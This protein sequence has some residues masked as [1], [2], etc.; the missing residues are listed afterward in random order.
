MRNPTLTPVS[1]LDAIDKV[2]L[3]GFAQA[4]ITLSDAVE[5]AEKYAFGRAVSGGLAEADGGLIFLVVVVAD[6]RLKEV[7]IDPSSQN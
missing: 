5:I 7:S 4:G 3:A 2:E 1:T 6:G